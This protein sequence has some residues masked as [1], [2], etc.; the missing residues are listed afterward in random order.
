[1]LSYFRNIFLFFAVLMLACMMAACSK[2]AYFDVPET[3]EAARP[4]MS[5]K[6]ALS[7]R[8]GAD[9]AAQGFEAGE[10]LENFLDVANSNF[11]IYF[12]DADNKFI[13]VFRPVVLSFDSE[14]NLLTDRIH[15][16][17][18]VQFQDEMP[19]NLPQKFKI[20]AL[21]NWRRYPADTYTS[22]VGPDDLVLTPGVTTI[23]DLCT[24]SSAQFDALTLADGDDSW[25][26]K[27]GKL[28][29][30]Y[31]VRE[32]DINDYISESDKKPDGNI[33]G[34]TIIDLSKKGDEDTSVPLL[35]ALAKVEVILDN[36][37]ASFSEVSLTRVNRK[38]FCAP[39][40]ISTA[41]KPWAYDHTDY[42]PEG[43]YSWNNNFVRGVH[44]TYGADS[45]NKGYG[46]NDVSAEPFSLPFKKV[47]DRVET[48]GADG[49]V[50][51]V[52]ER[53]I[54]YVPEYKNIGVED[55]TTVRVRLKNPS[56]AN[57]AEVN[58]P[59]GDLRYY[60]DIYF[61]ENGKA[62]AARFDI[63]R[64]NIYR[65]NIASMNGDVDV[66]L[67]VQPFAEQKLNFEFGLMRDERGDLMVLPVPKL[68]ADG[69][70]VYDAD[71]NPV[72]TYPDYFLDFI[73]DDNPKHKYPQE[74]DE[75][76]NPTTGLDIVLEEGDYYAIVVGE[77][78]EMSDAVVWV[79]D[80]DGCHVLSNLESNLADQE[81][82]ARLVESFYGN[83]QSERFFKDAFGYRRVYHF[84]NHNS[85]V[86]HPR[87]DNL[88]FRYIENFKQENQTF[89]YYLVESWD[90]T[91]ATGWIVNRDADG[92]EVS[93]Q[94]I[95]SDGELGVTVPINPSAD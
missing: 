62:D 2:D 50:S 11:C 46:T 89:K 85:I 57:D 76:G 53:W 68:D 94:E 67:D 70:P 93:F 72:M 45:S 95:T 27:D 42:F 40:R 6:V 16:V 22:N 80:K 81:C 92:N 33:K 75:Y 9:D 17:S 65:F 64:N 13:D 91:T 10:G 56:T 4:V 58:Q 59:G 90:D 49:V 63:E 37:I 71:G 82:N 1:M 15:T 38:G 83:N 14:D 47:T 52:P 88:L 73:N 24:H 35:R 60:K 87:I 77:Y 5:I 74:E 48:V 20:V 61:A 55:F 51:V 44:L 31:G 66:S 84:D 86:R 34:G 79:K 26:S 19:D 18:Y 28:I 78:D 3:D 54:A 43:I 36:P 39:Y 12:F 21:F 7:G 41:E 29:P 25:L 32:Y 23:E 69:N 8:A 30:F